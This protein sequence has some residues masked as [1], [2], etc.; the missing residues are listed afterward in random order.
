VTSASDEARTLYLRGR[1]LSDQLR[2]HD[3]RQHFEQAAAKDPAFALAHYDLA[4][5]SPTPKDFLEHLDEA[6]KLSSR[7]SEGERLMILA[8]QAGSNGDSRKSLEYTQELA[9]KYPRDARALT[10]LGF[11]YTGVQEFDKAVGTLTKAAE[12]DP[13][14]PPVYNLLGYTYMPEGKYAEAEAAFKKYIELVPGDPNPYDSYAELLMRTG[15]FDESIAQYRKA[16]SID[17]HFSNAHVGIAANLMYQGKHEAAAAEAQKL[18]DAARD[19]GDRRSAVFTRVVVYVDQGRTAQALR[20]MEKLYALGAKLGDTAAMSGDAQQTGDILLSAGR[21]DEALKHY[22][23][24]LALVEA[25]SLS[26]EIKENTKL[27]DH[28]NLARV[29]L[30]KR[31]LAGAKAHAEQYRSGAEATQDVGRI[32]TAHELA[33]RIALEEKKFD[34]AA[35]HLGQADQQDPFVLYTMATAYQG[36]GDA[37]KAKEFAKRA[38]DANIL[39]TLRYAFARSKAVKMGG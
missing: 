2:F 18:H 23:Q 13:G 19:D 16:L 36:N 24:A 25:S 11:A 1:E 22:R 34:E 33:G 9:A 6:V 20:E 35:D 32:R 17:P 3:A 27:A 29:A 7:A 10:L 37:A 26:A 21:A 39:P 30:A 38:A 28:D 12:V 4:I 14:H 15:R 31:D 5:T 8:L